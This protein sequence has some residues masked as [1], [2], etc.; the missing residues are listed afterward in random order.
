[1][2]KTITSS[3]DPKKHPALEDIQK[4]PPF[5]FAR[6]LSG[7]QHTIQAANIFNTYPAIPIENQY[8]MVKTAFAGKIRFIPYPKNKSEEPQKKV[9]YLSEHFKISESAASEYL[10]FISK[11]ELD[12]IV[13]M[14]TERDL[15]K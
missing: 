1:M 13:D 7:N 15:K 8:Q 9:Q 10:E 5:I 6:W 14:Y 11:E 12:Y 3:L 4:I 2:F